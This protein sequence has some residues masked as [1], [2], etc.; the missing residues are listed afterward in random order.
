MM[1]RD[2]LQM[3]KKF[4]ETVTIKIQQ[5]PQKDKITK[6]KT[7]LNFYMSLQKSNNST[8]KQYTTKKSSYNINEQK[9]VIKYKKSDNNINEPIK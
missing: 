2:M 8:V 6:L 7:R 4:K 9:I 1:C 3:V 5:C